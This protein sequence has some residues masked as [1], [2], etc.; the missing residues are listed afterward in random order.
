MIVVGCR[1]LKVNWVRE[2]AIED[3]CLFFENAES[4]VLFPCIYSIQELVDA[5]K[6][7]GWCPDFD[8]ADHVYKFCTEAV[9]LY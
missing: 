7:N 6:A 2:I 3:G 4:A 1:K 8:N 5:G 9:T